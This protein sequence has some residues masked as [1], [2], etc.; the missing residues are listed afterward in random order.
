MT[1]LI[2]QLHA[3][4]GPG[5][6]M[7]MRSLPEWFGHEGGLADCARAVRSQRG[8]VAEED[9]QVRG[10]V[11]WEPRTTVTAEATWMAVHR[12][13]RNQGIGTR[14]LEQL[15]DD[16]RH[17]GFRLLLAL[18]SAASRTPD[19]QPDSY[20]ATRQFW[21]RRGFLPVGAFDLTG[22][23]TNLALVLVRPL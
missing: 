6:D 10:F 20:E 1:V 14:I 17:Q 12:D 9:G 15:A 3:A 16:V 7:I 5:C 22:W 23:E 11:T 2:R 18:T 8:L 21:Q 13:T 4:D 19:G